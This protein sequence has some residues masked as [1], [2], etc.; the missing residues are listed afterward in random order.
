[1]GRVTMRKPK[2]PKRT[3]RK[4]LAGDDLALTPDEL[5]K[6]RADLL[7]SQA[8]LCSDISSH[9]EGEGPLARHLGAEK[10]RLAGKM[11]LSVTELDEIIPCMEEGWDQSVDPAIAPATKFTWESSRAAGR[12]RMDE[13]AEKYLESHQQGK[14]YRAIAKDDLRDEPDGEA[15]KLLIEKES[16]RIRASVRRARRRKNT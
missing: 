2:G 8:L 13:K 4:P 5:R 12:P 6:A 16:E 11:S 14:S 3:R 10:Q 9:S 7:A 1:M 15:K